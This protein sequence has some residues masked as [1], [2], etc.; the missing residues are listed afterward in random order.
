MKA[1]SDSSAVVDE[2]Q[3]QPRCSLDATL[4]RRQKRIS[5]IADPSHSYDW[6]VEIRRSATERR[7]K[8]GS[9]VHVPILV[10]GSYF[11]ELGRYH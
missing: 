3:R 7:I 6:Y 11:H 9:L 1:A 5:L 2:R 8:H 4:V 10:G